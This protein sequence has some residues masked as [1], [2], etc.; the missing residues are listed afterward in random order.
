MQVGR[1]EFDIGVDNNGIKY[2]QYKLHET[3]HTT[4]CILMYANGNFHGYYQIHDNSYSS[5]RLQLIKRDILEK[6]I[7]DFNLLSP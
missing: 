5:S 3:S 6:Y 2:Y 1:I 7:K 4:T